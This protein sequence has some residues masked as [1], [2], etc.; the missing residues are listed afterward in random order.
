MFSPSIWWC[1]L[2]V[3]RSGSLVQQWQI[4]LYGVRPLSVFRRRPNVGADE[5]G[6]VA[7]KLVVRLVVEALDGC[8]LDGAVHAFDLTVGPG[9][10][11]FGKSM[12]DVIL[13]AGEFEG[14][15]P[16]HFALLHGDFD[17]GCR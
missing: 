17:L 6:Q 11:W 4:A 10:A 8:F 5:V 16:E 1:G 7:A 2:K 15:G 14:V 3:N 13:R 12:V 9:M